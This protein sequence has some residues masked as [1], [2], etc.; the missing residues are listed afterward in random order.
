VAAIFYAEAAAIA[1]AGGLVGFGFGEWLGGAISHTIFGSGIQPQFQLL[2][3]ILL[4]ALLVVFIGCSALIQ[5][6]A[7]LAPAVVLR[8]EL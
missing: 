4:V 5:R 8:G 2:P 7:R 1:I 6:A 3:V